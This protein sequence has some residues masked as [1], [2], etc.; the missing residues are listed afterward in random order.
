MIGHHEKV[1]RDFELGGFTIDQLGLITAGQFVRIIRRQR[2]TKTKGIT[3]QRRMP[4]GV[5]ELGVT[6]RI[7]FRC[8]ASNA[9]RGRQKRC[10][11][12]YRKFF[13]FNLH[14]PL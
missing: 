4:V 2:I 9:H 13:W 14:S 3:R 8:G 7:G 6:L 10:A 1:L 11:Q 5:A 12:Q